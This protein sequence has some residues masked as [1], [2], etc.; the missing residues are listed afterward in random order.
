VEQARKMIFSALALPP[1][2]L[3]SLFRGGEGS[4]RKLL[5]RP[6]S[7][8]SAGWDLQTGADAQISRG[9]M[10]RV[11]DGDR[12]VLELYRDGT[13]IFICRADDW[14]LSWASPRGKQRLNPLALVEVTFS[15][16]NFYRSVVAD[17]SQVPNEIRVRADFRDLH[18]GGQKT[19]L[20]PHALG[21]YAQILE[22]EVHHAP[23]NDA[24]FSRKFAASGFDPA[25][26]AYELVRE[27]YLWFGID[28]D[29]IP[30]VNR[31]SVTPKI[32]INAIKGSN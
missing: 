6:T 19:S 32:D 25:V 2:E 8:R 7:L 22:M 28:E 1:S 31:D 26:A 9:Q 11:A 24:T 21:T 30:Y 3:K 10:V 18:A 17:L 29:K 5:E 23:D 14:F 15:F 27:I 20:V 16:M 12:K 13:F 4:I